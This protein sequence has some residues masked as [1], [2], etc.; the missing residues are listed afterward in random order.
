MND[1]FQLYLLL[2]LLV[3]AWYGAYV[4]PNSFVHKDKLGSLL[5]AI[6]VALLGMVFITLELLKK[7]GK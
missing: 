5:G 3:V 1:Y 7:K 4:T 6:L 2:N